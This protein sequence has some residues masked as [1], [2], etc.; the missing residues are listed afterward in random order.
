MRVQRKHD[1]VQAKLK[2]GKTTSKRRNSR[3]SRPKHQGT[4]A[5]WKSQRDETPTK[6]RE[7]DS[8]QKIGK[9]SESEGQGE[10]LTRDTPD[11]K[12]GGSE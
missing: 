10:A 9:V 7:E 5:S 2:K 11:N 8:A 4:P 1:I 6:R 3:G 12:E